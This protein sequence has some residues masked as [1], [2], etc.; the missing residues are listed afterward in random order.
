M[1]SYKPSNHAV[2]KYEFD[3]LVGASGARDA[4]G[5]RYRFLTKILHG[6]PMIN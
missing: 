1:G 5:G 6:D 3:V 4:L 2:S